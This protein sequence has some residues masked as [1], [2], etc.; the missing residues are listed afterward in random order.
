MYQRTE[1]FLRLLK[2]KIQTEFNY[3]TVLSFDELNVIKLSDTLKNTYDSLGRFNHEHYVQI[4]NEAHLF[5]LSLLDDKERL[6]E[7]AKEFDTEDIVNY[8]IAN[9]NIITGYLYRKE[10]ERKRLRL[11]EEMATGREF[12]DRQRYTKA[13]RRSAN[14]WYTQSMQY[15]IDIEDRVLLN[16]FEKAGVKKVRWIAEHDE[17]TCEVCSKRDGKVYEINAIPNKTHYNCR[18][19]VVP[20]RETDI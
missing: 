7:A 15:A 18:C 13:I 20:V 6:K 19:Y 11:L 5:A 3:L 12:R 10:T 1:K 2:K 16:T 8:V 9:Y 14:L 17:K 4:A